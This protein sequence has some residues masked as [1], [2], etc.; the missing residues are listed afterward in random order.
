MICSGV[1]M[2]GREAS[3]PGMGVQAVGRPAGARRDDDDLRAVLTDVLR[4]KLGAGDHLDVLEL[5]ELDG[6]PV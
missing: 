2:C 5:L 4:G 6:T 1:R 3:A